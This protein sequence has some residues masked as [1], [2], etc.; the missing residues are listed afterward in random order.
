MYN[1]EETIWVNQALFQHKDTDFNTNSI[2]ETSL[3]TST[4]DLRTFSNP[5]VNLSITGLNDKKRRNCSLNIQ[6]VSSI[7]SSFNKL[8]SAVDKYYDEGDYEIIRKLSGKELQIA[9]KRSKNNQL[10]KC[11]LISIFINQSDFGRIILD[12]EV[13][14]LLFSSLE[15]LYDRN[16][17]VG[18]SNRCLLTSLLDKIEEM[19]RSIK[20]LPSLIGVITNIPKQVEE[21]AILSPGYEELDKY[22]G[23]SEMSNIKIPELEGNGV[24]KA[25]GSQIIH[26]EL[27]N[28][29]LKGD[30]TN[31]ESLINS[32]YV[33]DTP[34]LTIIDSIKHGPINSLEDSFEFLPGISDVEMKS[35]LY[36]SKVLFSSAF[37]NYTLNGVPLPLG[38]PLLIFKPDTDKVKELNVEIAIDLLLIVSYIKALKERLSEKIADANL[39]KSVVYFALRC[40]CDIMIFSFLD[41]SSKDTVKSMLLRNFKNYKGIGFFSTYESLL[42]RH[43]CTQITEQDILK[44]IEG[45]FPR[46]VEKFY[47]CNTQDFLYSKGELVLPSNNL[48]NIEQITKEVVRLEVAEKLGADL[49]KPEEMSKFVDMNTISKDIVKLFTEPK[50][51]NIIKRETPIFKYIKKYEAEIPED[52]KAEFLICINDISSSDSNF[53]FKGTSFPLEQLGD[54]IIKGLYEY[55]ES[56]KKEA[57]ANFYMRAEGSLLTKDLII[58][59]MKAEENQKTIEWGSL[60]K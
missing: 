53:N 17:T 46:L 29:V 34:I 33:M 45:V 49:S 15:V 39:N 40:F 1:T 23:G 24:V 37:Q 11:V 18:I 44:F 55:N 20:S 8:L 47:I 59:K 2:I 27:I 48:F 12:F 22:I 7:L 32:S 4:Q 30:I 35:E 13:A 51:R 10:Q 38:S 21:E 57:Y 31:L 52:I 28:N 54:H 25:E 41:G 3:S 19:N 58:A 43:S 56:N 5:F 36:V 9:F 6:A 60:S 26:S 16:V 50:R 42:D 14:K